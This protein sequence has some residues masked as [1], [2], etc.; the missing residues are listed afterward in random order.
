[1]NRKFHWGIAALIIVLIAAGGFMYWQWS[2]VQQLKEQ[3][4]QDEKLLEEK[5]KPVAENKP[6]LAKE[7]FKMV[8]HGD[9]WHEVP[10]DAPDVWQGEPH[11]P[12]VQPVQA[13]KTHTGPL[14]FHKELLETHPVEAV[15]QQAREAGHWSAEHIPPFPPDDTE[16]AEFARELYLY[17]YY[18]WT[19]QTDNPAYQKALVA[20]GEIFT[21]IRG[22][23]DKTPWEHARS[24]DL[25]KLIWPDTTTG[26]LPYV[27]F[28]TTFTEGIN[29]LTA[30]PL[31]PFE[32]EMSN[33]QTAE[34]D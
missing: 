31:L 17:R 21:G 29:P 11:E 15:R 28:T 34:N 30:R 24:N 22:R 27:R 18:K 32:L 16:A 9:H 2:T 5:K 14:T 20:Q 6:P 33:R 4:A 13:P 26:P 10:I 23:N 25:F 3:L 19:G 1:M 12:T 7:G 8:P